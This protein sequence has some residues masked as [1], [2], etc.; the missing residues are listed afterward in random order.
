M[1]RTFQD[2]FWKIMIGIGLIREVKNWVI[3]FV[4]NSMIF[5]RNC[6]AI[7]NI[8]LFF[9]S[10]YNHLKYLTLW[11]FRSLR[12][13]TGWRKQQLVQFFTLLFQVSSQQVSSQTIFS[14]LYCHSYISLPT[15]RCIVRKGATVAWHLWTCNFLPAILG[16]KS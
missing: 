15:F 4:L 13:W 11:I 5:T 16:S 8:W 9:W 12:I 3:S 2:F 10:V 1:S 14:S 7:F 6:T